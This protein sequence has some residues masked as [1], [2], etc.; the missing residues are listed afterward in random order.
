MQEDYIQNYPGG[1]ANA[2]INDVVRLVVRHG[3]P[4]I[5]LDEYLRS[6]RDYVQEILV[7]NAEAVD[8]S[9]LN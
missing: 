7:V 6:A 1:R 8:T 9:R 4:L 5:Y 3:V 2:F